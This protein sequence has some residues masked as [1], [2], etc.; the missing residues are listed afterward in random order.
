MPSSDHITADALVTPDAIV[1]LLSNTIDDQSGSVQVFLVKEGTTPLGGTKYTVAISDGVHCLDCVIVP[2]LTHLF[3]T[4]AVSM[5]STVTILRGLPVP[6]WQPWVCSA[7][8]TICRSTINWILLEQR[9]HVRILE[10]WVANLYG[11]IQGKATMVI[12]L[13]C[14]VRITR[15][16]C[17]LI[18]Y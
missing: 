17:S 16:K 4:K 18:G 7:W 10:P 12:L 2:Q 15:W 13:T 5:Y 8:S 11:R 6:R 1:T 3:V 14:P 9:K